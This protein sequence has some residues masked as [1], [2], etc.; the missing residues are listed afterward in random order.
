[1]NY[2][3]ICLLF[4]RS[5]PP[6]FCRNE[7]TGRNTKLVVLSLIGLLWAVNFFCVVFAA[8]ACSL[9]LSH[10]ALF[11]ALLGPLSWIV[12]LRSLRELPPGR[13]SMLP[14]PLRQVNDTSTAVL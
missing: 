9:R 3:F 14:S 11:A 13:V 6:T 7:S 8:R 10:Y 12:L 4:F 2:L 1:L 5:K